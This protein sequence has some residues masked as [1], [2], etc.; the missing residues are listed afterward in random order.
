VTAIPAVGS[1]AEPPGWEGEPR[2]EPGIHG[3]ARPRR[4]DAVAAAEA[5]GLA[6]DELAFAVLADGTVVGALE[7]EALAPLVAALGARRPPDRAE[8][9][10]HAGDRWAVAAARIR[11]VELPDVPGDEVELVASGGETTLRVDGRPWV[12]P[13]PALERLAEPEAETV[14][15]ARRLRGTAW[16]VETTRL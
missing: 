3:I 9:V 8:A 5:P 1:P 12:A 2:G 7:P 4:W 14:V 13:L 15:R 11:V 6:G 10:R 16:E